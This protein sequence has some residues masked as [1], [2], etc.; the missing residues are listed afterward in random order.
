MLMTSAKASK[1]LKELNDQIQQLQEVDRKSSVFLAAMGEDPETVRPEY[2][3]KKISEEISKLQEKV[4]I[5]KHALNVFNTTTKLTRYPMTI[6]EA[7]VFLPQLTTDKK[8]LE[9]MAVR[10]PK[11]RKEEVYGRSNIID[12]KYTNY[13]IVEAKTLLDETRKLLHEIQLDLNDINT[14]VEFEVNI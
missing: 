14:S 9:Q 1:K 6:D 7:L 4:R 12:Y 2:D 8:R 3:F 11:E 13:D 10:L 5:I